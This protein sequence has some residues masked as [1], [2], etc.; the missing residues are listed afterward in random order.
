MKLVIGFLYS[1]VM[2]QYGDRGNILCVA[3]RCRWRGIDAEMT[4]DQF[5]TVLYDHFL[6]L[7]QNGVIMSC[8]HPVF[9]P[10][11][12]EPLKRDHP[13]WLVNGDEPFKARAIAGDCPSP[14]IV[15]LVRSPLIVWSRVVVEFCALARGSLYGTSVREQISSY[16]NMLLTHM[17]EKL[18]GQTQ[19]FRTYAAGA[20]S[21][22]PL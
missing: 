3:K 18:E 19:A 21:G 20:M 6:T 4:E 15:F 1:R 14:A 13:D 10:M 8:S 22:N 12:R 2:S 7:A 16:V 17:D 11:N 5:L 9:P